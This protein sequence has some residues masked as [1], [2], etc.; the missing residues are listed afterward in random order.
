MS[1]S[2]DPAQNSV[3]ANREQHVRAP[4]LRTSDEQ[5]APA[6]KAL[7]NGDTAYYTGNFDNAQMHFQQALAHAEASQERPNTQVAEASLNLAML[8]WL[9]DARL[10]HDALLKICQL[11]LDALPNSAKCDVIRC[12]LAVW[13]SARARWRGDFVTAEQALTQALEPTTES[14]K[15]YYRL[16]LTLERANIARNRGQWSLAKRLL[17]RLGARISVQQ[18]PDPEWPAETVLVLSLM[19]THALGVLT[20]DQFLLGRDALA[21]VASARSATRQAEEAVLARSNLLASQLVA[22]QRSQGDSPYQLYVLRNEKALGWV[23]WL[24]GHY[25]AAEQ[26]AKAV[27]ADGGGAQID[28]C[29]RVAAELLQAAALAGRDGWEAGAES[30]TH[31]FTCAVKLDYW[32]GQVLA[33]TLATH[34][35]EQAGDAAT[36]EYWREQRRALLEGRDVELDADDDGVRFARLARRW[37]DETELLSSV[38]KIVFHPAYQG[39]MAMGRAA[40]PWI[41]DD[42]REHGADHWHWA[43]HH[44]TGENPVPPDLAGRLSAIRDCWL[45]WADANGYGAGD[46]GG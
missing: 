21:G 32:K 44:I 11:E 6:V 37:R 22:S 40:L 13:T 46:D 39:I 23:D 30:L 43:L 14:G 4:A 26:R 28:P 7:R 19:H 31:A 1:R 36:A 5:R 17:K 20:I 42:L 38:S 25:D 18:T 24:C 15:R 35:A 12:D 9:R 45:A 34:C 8:H 2:R 16:R 27:L 29:A 3:R 33:A 10:E 41:F